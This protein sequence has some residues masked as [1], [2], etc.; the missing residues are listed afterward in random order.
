MD[1]YIK[2]I[3]NLIEYK[4]EEEWFEFKENWFEAHGIGEYISA[5]SNGAVMRDKEYAYLVW[6]IQDG[7]HEI[8]GTSFDFHMDFKKEPL[9]HYLARQINPDVSFSFK[10]IEIDGKRLV[11]LEIPCAAK[12]PTS[13]D[14]VRY[15]RIGSSK[16]NVAK[17]PEREAKLFES[18]RK[19]KCS[20]QSLESEY[21]ELTFER[22]FTYY[23]GKGITLNAKNFKKNLGLFTKDGKH[24]L[25]AQLLSDDSHIPIRISVFTGETK[26][27]PLYSIKEFGNTCILLS[28]DKV[29]EY[30]DVINLIQTDEKNR[31]LSRK[32]I[33]LFDMNAFREA[34]IN[35]FVHNKWVDRNAPMITVYS[36]RIEILSRGT[37][38]PNQTMEGFYLG[39]SIPVNQKL[40][41][42]FLQ[43]H[44][45]ERSGRGVPKII[46]TY[47]KDVFD[48]RENSIVVNI[49][50]N[51]INRHIDYNVGDKVVNKIPLNP[52]RKRI[53]EEIRNNPNI[54]QIQLMQI[55]GIGKTAMQNNINF[56]KE[57]GYIER[58]GSNKAGY[59][60]IKLLDG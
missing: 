49:P 60:N 32:D 23:A 14:G 2:L 36:N 29:L 57:Y 44:I 26:A 58:I 9:E 18:L 22:L 7:T 1:K 34:A 46:D 43:L 8:V 41:D 45:S 40:S 56:L 55:I 42:I 53:L 47:G 11:V 27:S 4:T 54:T 10:E 52:R 33:P 12:I 28:L 3:N 19:E 37:L 20:I 39:E 30:A 21:Q 25:L 38:A 17:Y 16:V 24:N 6:G 15:I 5:L 35:A 59:W 31:M 51:R 48:F 13:F 50:F